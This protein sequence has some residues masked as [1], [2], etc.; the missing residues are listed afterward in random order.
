MAEPQKCQGKH[1]DRIGREIKCPHEATHD[2]SIHCIF[3]AQKKSA[4]EY[5]SALQLLAQKWIDE[6]ID[7]W[8]LS[9]F[10]FPAMIRAEDITSIRDDKN[11]PV[12]PVEVSFSSATFSGYA[13]FGRATFSRDADFSYAMFSGAAFFRRV[14]FSR[15]AFLSSATFSGDADFSYATFSGAALFRSAKLNRSADFRSVSF[16]RL[17]D[18]SKCDIKGSLTFNA[19]KF[20]KRGYI[21][22]YRAAFSAE[23]EITMRSCCLS[24]LIMHDLDLKR[25][26]FEGC[27]FERRLGRA[28]ICEELRARWRKD[29]WFP[30][31][32]ARWDIILQHYEALIA[33]FARREDKRKVYALTHSV[34][35]MRRLTPPLDTALGR[36]LLAASDFAEYEDKGF[37]N[38]LWAVMPRTLL[39]LFKRYLSLPALYR[40]ASLYGGSVLLPVFWIL[41]TMGIFSGFYHALLYDYN[42]SFNLLSEEGWIVSL[43]VILQNRRWLSDLLANPPA[44]IQYTSGDTL[45]VLVLSALQTIIIA[46]F[47]MLIIFAVR[48][49]FKH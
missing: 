20:K 18:F 4:N 36:A 38:P 46:V 9:G 14:T 2:N 6:E 7:E 41:A 11:N 13:S 23:G 49:R 34:F 17:G 5:K 44:G 42:R 47:I 28:I 15:S 24:R 39:H 12:F 26:R 30:R 35:E 21:D 22:L 27:H 25:L 37:W 19:L 8:N 16:A 48:R 45:T 3:H 10:V 29:H 43:H 31:A 33:E 1:Y 32:D 40:T